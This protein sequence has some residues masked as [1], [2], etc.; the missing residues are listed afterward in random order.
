MPRIDADDRDLQSD[1][2]PA[3]HY[4]RCPLAEVESKYANPE[5]IK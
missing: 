3:G 4:T 2:V 5:N 1:Q